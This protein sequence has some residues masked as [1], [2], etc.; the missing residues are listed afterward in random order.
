MVPAIKCKHEYKYCKKHKK[1]TKKIKN[2]DLVHKCFP[3]HFTI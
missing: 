1:T 2:K 3:L